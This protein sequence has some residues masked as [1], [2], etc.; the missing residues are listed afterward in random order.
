MKCFL[1]KIVPGL[2]LMSLLGGS[3]C[4]QGRLATIDLKKVFENYY[5]KKQAQ[6]AIDD[7]K[8]D[9]EKDIKSMI[10]EYEKTNGVYQT[11]LAD[12]NNSALSADER[13]KRKKSAE[14][15]F[16]QLKEMEDSI[17]KYQRQAET[18][19]DEQRSRLIDNIVAEIRTVVTAKAKSA[20]FS[21]V[22]DTSATS[23]NRT[24]VVLYSNNEND[25][26]DAILTQ[27]NLAAPLEPPKTEEK[28]PKEEKKNGK[29]KDDKKK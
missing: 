11:M 27:L 21:L 5:K 8:A 20:G 22:F 15:A 18:T 3:A 6:A 2:L 14:E 29:K 4:A 28:E 23:V 26:T 1:L 25:L 13:E 10:G 19:L 9:M 16:K 12:A 7:R 24:P 17:R